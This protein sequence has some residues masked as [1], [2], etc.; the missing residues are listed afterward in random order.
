MRLS[1]KRKRF[2]KQ[3][4]AEMNEAKWG[5]QSVER[6]D[7]ACEGTST[8]VSHVDDSLELPAPLPVMSSSE[9]ES[10][11]DEEYE[12]KLVEDDISSIY[13]D[14]RNDMKRVDQQRMAMMLYDNYRTRFLLQKTA[15]A[16]EVALF[17]NISEKTVRTWR[18][19]F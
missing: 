10:D 12:S 3:R 11:S 6:L 7:E 1:R 17:L 2:L 15:A 8:D 4:A 18:K 14:W 5:R 9:G 13:E 16:Q 19:K